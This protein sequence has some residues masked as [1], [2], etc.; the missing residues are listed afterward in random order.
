MALELIV[1]IVLVFTVFFNNGVQAYIHYEA[2]PLF[3]YVGKPEFATYL[4]HNRW[5]RGGI[6]FATL[7]VVGSNNNNQREV[8]GAV[9][10]FRERDAAN[11]AWV[12]AAF[13]EARAMGRLVADQYAD[14]QAL[15]HGAV[16]G[17]ATGGAGTDT[18][19]ATAAPAC[20]VAYP[21]SCSS[22]ARTAFHGMTAGSAPRAMSRFSAT[23]MPGTTVKCW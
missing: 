21:N 16:T 18:G 14:Q 3:A 1:F 20:R 13:A 6:L 17:S 12:K 23:V 4:E 5:S 10:E 11:A 19:A 8:P 9:A 2:Y 22:S 7:H 15:H